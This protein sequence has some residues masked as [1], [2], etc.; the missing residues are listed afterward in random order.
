MPRSQCLSSHLVSPELPSRTHTSL[1]LVNNHQDAL[2]LRQFS[3]ATE[4]RWACVVISALGLDGLNDHC[5]DRIAELI[6]DLLRFTQAPVLL[7]LILRLMR[8]EGVAQL[9]EGGDRPVKGRNIQLVYRL[10]PC[11]RQ[12][13]EQAAVEARAEGQ[14]RVVRRARGLIQHD[15]AQLSVGEVN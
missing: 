4:E 11:R 15:G 13:A 3:Q 5:R 7:C 9:R 1:N 8:F 2:A 12:T 10:A 6:D 14:Y